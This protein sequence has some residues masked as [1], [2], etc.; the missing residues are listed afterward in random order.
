MILDAGMGDVDRQMSLAEEMRGT[1]DAE[2]YSVNRGRTF[3]AANPLEHAVVG[4]KRWKGARD[5][6]RLGTEQTKGRRSF[7]DLLRNRDKDDFSETEVD[8]QFME[9]EDRYA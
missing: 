8:Y 4:A 6:K 7:I 2:G 9:S 5:A 1:A 3:V